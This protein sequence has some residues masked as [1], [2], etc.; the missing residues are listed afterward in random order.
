MKTCE[1]CGRSNSDFNIYCIGC[2]KRLSEAQQV[3][4]PQQATP[5]DDAAPVKTDGNTA[6]ALPVDDTLPTPSVDY[7]S[8]VQPAEPTPP[9]MPVPPASQM[10]PPAPSGPPPQFG[11]YYSS[12]IPYSYGQ[13]EGEHPFSPIRNG[14]GFGAIRDLIGSGLVL[15]LLILGLT[16]IILSAM[17][18]FFTSTFT[19]ELLSQFELSDYDIGPFTYL[20]SIIGAIIGSAPSVLILIG[21]FMA[22]RSANNINNAMSPAGFSMIRVVTIIKFVFICIV[23]LLILIVGVVI[24]GGTLD[25]YFY[26]IIKDV[27]NKL[28]ESGNLPNLDGF[29]VFGII[30]L[31]GPILI[32]IDIMFGTFIVFAYIVIFKFLGSIINTIRT[33]IPYVKGATAFYVIAFILGGFSAL[34]LIGSLGEIV[35]DPTDGLFQ[36]VSTALGA[37]IY[38]IS[39]VLAYKYKKNAQ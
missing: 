19:S 18:A 25:E 20:G 33:G 10:P 39:G 21:L 6:S 2:G 28:E 11:R 30:S 8:P 38:F 17:S 26:E 9:A 16:Q 5:A 3:N 7:V 24:A 14:G 1:S 35:S 34:G 4:P 13:S 29:N 27:L 12:P 32:L 37:S 22:Y 23:I 36:F 31:L 15:A